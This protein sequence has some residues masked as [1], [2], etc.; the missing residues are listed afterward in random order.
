MRRGL[1][2]LSS[3]LIRGSRVR[4]Y[5]G[6]V[7]PT[8]PVQP[9]EVDGKPL[10]LLLIAGEDDM[11]VAIGR[12]S[13]NGETLTW[14]GTSGELDIPMDALPRLRRAH[15]DPKRI[16]EGAD[17]YVTL[18][19]GPLPGGAVESGLFKKKGLTWP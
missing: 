3:P 12:A 16:F 1:G 5:A 8:Q 15:E 4:T 17:F 13:W 18:T 10:A 19:V 14:K 9:E 11:A 2:L 6:F 7:N